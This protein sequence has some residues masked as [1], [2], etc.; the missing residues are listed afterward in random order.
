MTL[1]LTQHSPLGGSGAAR[2][3]PP[4]YGGGCYGSVRLSY[5][6]PDEESEYAA[7]GLA[8]HALA[9]LCLTTNSDAW[10]LIGRRDVAK[11][12]STEIEVDAPMADGVQVY[13]NAV[14]SKHPN[15]DAA[16]VVG[17][18]WVELEFHCPDIHEYCWGKADVVFQDEARRVLHVWDFKNGFMDVE[19]IENP[20]LMYY[21]NGILE[22]MELWEEV[23]RVVLH[24]CQPNGFN[25]D[26]PVREWTISTK[27]LWIWSEDVLV[28]A[29]D[30]AL[31]SRDTASGEHCRF[32]PARARACPQ[33]LRDMN[34]LERMLIHIA[35][36]NDPEK[37]MEDM[38]LNA[39]DAAPELTHEE[40]GRF[41]DLFDVAKI[42]C[43]AVDD[44][45]FGR[46]MAGRDIPNRKLVKARSNRDWKDG[47][48]KELEK[49]FGGDAYTEPELKSPSAVEK[50]IGGKQMTA[51]HAF[52]PDKGL[53][54]ARAD[55]KRMA[56]DRDPSKGFVDQT[57]KG[58]K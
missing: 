19:V 3:M 50:M 56:V 27:D 49:K 29:M 28:P 33:I 1:D 54:V 34:E 23:D 7:R 47:A 42:A 30:R 52:K 25:S 9:E 53:T 41:K 5:G 57:K 12:I 51:R 58:K 45:V 16:R 40:C 15:F 10:Q 38:K 4:P 13:L 44:T 21:A 31:A 55:D 18:A 17:C 46:M 6:V 37:F 2:W 43:K 35:R 26:G 36:T 20:Q 22:K 32:C 8:A 48:E 24:I 14:R 39:D 11:N